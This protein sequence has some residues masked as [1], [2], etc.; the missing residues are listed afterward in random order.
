MGCLAPRISA[1]SFADAGFTDAVFP[2][3]FCHHAATVRHSPYYGDIISSQNRRG[4][5]ATLARV[6]VG[7][8]VQHIIERASPL[9]VAGVVVRRVAITMTGKLLA[10]RRGAMEDVCKQSV[11]LPHDG[12]SVDPQR[13]AKIRF[14]D[15]ARGLENKAGRIGSAGP[16]ARYNTVGRDGVIRRKRDDDSNIIGII[17]I[18][19]SEFI[20]RCGQG[21]ALL[22]QRLRPAFYS[23]FALNHQGATA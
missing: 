19:H 2:G 3:Q 23:R 15:K 13:H 16:Y 4:I 20:L 17:G 21:L 11:K 1:P 7:N 14:P 9:H 18:S 8:L 12:L 5:S 10:F 6:T 22:T